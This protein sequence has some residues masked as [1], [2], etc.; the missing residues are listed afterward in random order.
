M[1]YVALKFWFSVFVFIFNLII[2]VY[3]F[4]SS[5]QRATR[6]HVDTLAKEIFGR[7]KKT[8]DKIITIESELEHLPGAKELHE[9][10]N[11]VGEL[12]G[13][14]KGLRASVDGMNTSSQAM[15]ST[16]TS[17]NNYLLENK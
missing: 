3:V 15:Q 5:R 7:I 8:E 10:S 16:L 1:D 12:S 6:N 2:A 13:D 17:I 4:I 11:K 14:L 9:V